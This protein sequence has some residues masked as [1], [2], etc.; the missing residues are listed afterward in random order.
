ARGCPEAAPALLVSRAGS[1]QRRTRSGP[2]GDLAAA[3][4]REPGRDERVILIAGEV[5]E[6]HGG[7]RWLEARPLF[8]WTVVVTRAAAQADDLARLLDERGAAVLEVPLIRVEAPADAAPLRSA[9]RDLATFDWI[10]FTSANGVD[11]VWTALEREALD[12]RA[13]RAARVACIGP[14]TAAALARRGIRP[15]LVPDAYVA[16]AL[17][18]AL[19]RAAELPATRILLPRAARG[20]PVLPDGLRAR[21]AEVLEVE[22]YRTVPE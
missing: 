22:T 2:L 7:L 4:A 9:I 21:G 1:P 8:G 5:V 14:G 18:D 17:L 3:A 15:D 13:L 16:E 11:W 10:V 12:S 19:D 20:R 6:T